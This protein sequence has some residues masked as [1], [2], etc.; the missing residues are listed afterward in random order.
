MVKT[1][2]IQLIIFELSLSAIL[3]ASFYLLNLSA[4]DSLTPFTG[5]HWLFLPA[6]IALLI[7]LIFP[8]AGPIGVGIAAFCLAHFIH[9]PNQLLASIGIGIT[10]GLAP[11]LSRLIAFNH[12]KINSDL[13]NLRFGNL[14][15]CVLIYSIVR[16]LLHHNWY[17]FMGLRSS[18]V[19]GLFV[20]F[21]GNTSEC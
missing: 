17:V 1:R 3:Y 7:S 19:K 18:S 13:S 4:S 10:A 20:E 12:L 11:Y 9:F 14:I 15:H 5:A 16:S 8:N 2:Q 6:G 21:V